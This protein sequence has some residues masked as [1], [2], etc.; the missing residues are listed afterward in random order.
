MSREGKQQGP[1]LQSALGIAMQCLRQGRFGEAEMVYKDVIRQ[2][3]SCA[4]ALF[5]LGLL[6]HRR[7]AV[8]EAADIF[9]KLVRIAP[10]DADATLSLAILKAEQRKMA[11]AQA[12]A[13]RALQ[14]GPSPA[15]MVQLGGLFSET[16]DTAKAC[17][18][19]GEAIRQQ[20]EN[21]KAH[22][23]LHTL[24]KYAVDDP[25]FL[26]LLEIEKKGGQLPMDERTM[27]SFILAKAYFD[28]D[29]SEKAFEH[30]ATGNRL[31]KAVYAGYDIAQHEKYV[32]SVIRLFDAATVAK[33]RPASAMDSSR[34]I[35][36]IGMMRSGS[37]LVDQIL[38]SHPDVESIGELPVL[39]K[40]LPYF[41]N[42]EM[43]G[44]FG[45]REPSIS[46]EMMAKLDA[47]VLQDI[48]K[49]YLSQTE[50]AANGARRVVDKMLFNY[51]W[52]GIIRLAMPQAKIIHCTRDPADIGLSIWGIMFADPL[53]WTYDQKSI[54]RY[55]RAYKK[56]MDHWNAIFP[57]EI[58]EVNY[59]TMIAD[60]ESETRRLL[61]F[62]GLPWDD[63][64][65][66]FHETSR[67]VKT[68][69][70]SQVRQPIYKDSVRKWEKYA[71]HL[72]DLITTLEVKA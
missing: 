35:F 49:K 69:S 71:A 9:E 24:K 47:G 72:A 12:L 70:L 25:D 37:T 19:L 1:S 28:Q 16:G 54:G 21:I 39:P 43:P 48:S 67:R 11:E 64:C 15:G 7:G 22:F 53:P 61:E 36:V 60:Q 18:C 51:L 31:R 50:P 29:N 6:A 66:K 27:L 45:P 13:E 46:L 2:D 68:S 62:C 41:A 26:R 42:A 10:Q 40:C 44:W 65:L 23:S 3:P 33:L 4:P 59:E 20:P 8:G 17:H 58:H 32:D 56:L 55:Y 57:G 63:R 14:L 38:S 30:L 52:T 34:P 5:N